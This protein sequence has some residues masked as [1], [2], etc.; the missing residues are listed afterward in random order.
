MIL[1]ESPESPYYTA[2]SEVRS[3]KA[4]LVMALGSYMVLISRTVIFLEGSLSHL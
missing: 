1:R 4:I 2:V 3:Q